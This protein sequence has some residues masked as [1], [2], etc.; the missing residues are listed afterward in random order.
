MTVKKGIEIAIDR[1]GTFTDVWANIPGK[2]EVTLKLLSDDPSNYK[3]APIEGIRRVLSIFYGMDLPRQTPLPK[4]DIS[5]IRM[6]TTVATNALLERKGSRHALIVTKGFKDVLE[7]GDQTRPQLFDLEIRKPDLLYHLVVEMDERVTLE[8]FDEDKDGVIEPCLAEDVVQS[9]ITGDY[10]RILNK[11]DTDNVR[12]KLQKIRAQGIT[13]LAVCFIHSYLYPDHEK[14]VGKIAHEL[15]FTNVS[16]SCDVGAKMIK[17]VSRCSSASA[18]AYLTPVIQDYIRGFASGFENGNLRGLSCEFMQSDGGLVNYRGFSGLK[19]ILSGPAGGVVGYAQTCYD[20]ESAV[21]GFDM[22]GTSTDVSRFG[23]KYEHVFETTTAGVTIQS[24]QLDI[25]TVAAGGGSICFWE[26]GLFRVGPESA[27]AHPGPACYRKGGP[28]TITDCNLFLGRILPEYFPSVFGPNEDQQLDVEITKSLL[29]SMAK[30]VTADSRSHITPTDVALG[31]I[32]VA[33]ES[34]ARP[35]RALTEARGHEIS[36][37]ILCS[38]GG[39]GGQHACEIAVSLGVKR[40]VIHKYSS[41]LSAY[42]MSLAEVVQEVQEPCSQIYSSNSYPFLCLRIDELKNVALEGLQK[43][44]FENQGISYECYLNMRYRGTDTSIMILQSHSKDFK[45]AFEDEHRRE[46][47]FIF[48]DEREVLVDDIRVRAIGKAET[49]E[50]RKTLLEELSAEFYPVHIGAKTARAVTFRLWGTVK[51]PIYELKSLH[52]GQY[53]DG[54]AMLIDDTQTIVVTPGS[55]AKVLNDHVVIDISKDS[56]DFLEPKTESFRT[57]A[58]PIKL[59]VFGNRFMSIAEQMGRTLQKISVS[60][61]MK[62]RLDFS[63]AIFGPDGELVAN[64]PHVPVHLGSMSY[65]VRYQHELLQGQ[66]KPG[67]ILV[68]NHPEAGGTHLPDIT[69]ITPVFD[70]SNSIIFYTASRG[71]HTDIGGLGGTSFPPNSTELWQEGA[72]IHSFKIVEDGIFNENETL[73]IFRKPGEYPG[74]MPSRRLEDNLSDLKAQIAANNKGLLLIKVLI[75]EYSKSEVH[76]YMNAIQ[77]NAEMAV[78]QYL[79]E[80]VERLGTSTLFSTDSMDNSSVIKLK[81]DIDSDLGSAVFDFTGTS[82]EI[83]GNMN[84][85]PAIT[86]SAIIYSMRLLVGQEIPLNQGCLAPIEVRLPKGSFL[87]PSDGPAVC[88]GNTQTSQRLVDVILRPFKVAAASQGCMNCLGFFGRGGQDENGNELGGF[89]YVYGETS[90][91]GSGAGPGFHGAS[92]VQVH[93]TNTKS[94]DVEVMERKFPVILRR[95][96]IR[97]GSGGRGQW[98]GGCGVIRDFECS[99]PLHFSIISERRVTE[100]YGM[101]GGKPGEKGGNYWLKVGPKLSRMINVGPKAMVP[102]DCGDHFIV[103][104]PGGGGWGCPDEE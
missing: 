63:C 28:L 14:L 26:N 65:A 68:S 11:L 37:H 95:F 70:D 22:G 76:Y 42:G 44:G 91:G 78:R 36:D 12:A 17:M 41:I 77:K 6:G 66:L 59:S 60:L 90:C 40:V 2:G 61:N 34:M 31:F 15:G 30:K 16:L 32:E 80:S 4:K 97:E 48:E 39:A 104:T 94:T 86:Y 20:G 10:I 47:T 96:E 81:V 1:G 55:K 23:G 38:F 5:T 24:P 51:T 29:E 99:L 64:A 101:N 27:S 71:H 54:P 89:A 46:F 82:H 13:N 74:C 69:V 57:T 21:I 56:L 7:I 84:A 25:N 35:I 52:S 18:D 73:D 62:E 79:K 85:P 19:G 49:L 58:D 98:N 75:N 83:Y 43:Q 50:K 93:M 9:A 67:D 102:L 45:L 3:D 72:A 53:L 100:P 92:A 33:N 103:H 87:N 88:A 8:T